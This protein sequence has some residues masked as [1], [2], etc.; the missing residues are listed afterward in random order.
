MGII[1]A[2]LF[3]RNVHENSTGET[4]SESGVMQERVYMWESAK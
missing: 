3:Y 4:N 1:L 2:R